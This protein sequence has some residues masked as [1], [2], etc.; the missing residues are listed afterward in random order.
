MLM[1]LDLFSAFVKEVNADNSRNYKLEVLKKWK[2]VE[3]VKFYLNYIFNP[4]IT[5]GLAE[6]KLDK[7]VLFV[8]NEEIQKDDVSLLNYIKIKR[9]ARLG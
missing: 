9:I 5:T 4:Y 8:I 6:K 1:Y 2:D 7:N 3:E